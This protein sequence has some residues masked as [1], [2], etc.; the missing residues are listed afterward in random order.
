VV[1]AA[2]TK[3]FGFMPFYPG[4]GLGGHCIPIDPHYLT[5]KVRTLDYQPRLIETAA[6]IN[7]GMPAYV[8]DKVVDALNEAEKSVKGSRILMM[9]AAYKRDINDMRESPALD[10]MQLLLRKGARIEYHDP[11]VPQLGAHEGF[12]EPLT[13]IEGVPEV[14]GDY[15]C[16]IVGTDHTSIDWA[17]VIDASRLVVDTRNVSDGHRAAHVVRL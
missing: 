16:V 2:A 1:R 8:V 11:F 4:P 13:S 17:A 9:G 6:E 12:D 5:W 7:A 14:C 10:I 15:D 3:P